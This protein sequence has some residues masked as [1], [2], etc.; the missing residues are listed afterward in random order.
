MTPQSSGTSYR[1][2][3]NPAQPAQSLTIGTSAQSVWS[4]QPARAGSNRPFLK[5]YYAPDTPHMR[6]FGIEGRVS[7]RTSGSHC[8]GLALLRF[9][10]AEREVSE[11][12]LS[13]VSRP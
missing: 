9:W 2:N 3:E 6:P 5:H 11:Y 7:V 13:A 1:L 10:V 8:P 12:V 4:R